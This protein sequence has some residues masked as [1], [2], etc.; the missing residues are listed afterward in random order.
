MLE[1][2]DKVQLHVI[3]FFEKCSNTSR[4]SNAHLQY[5]Y[6]T[7]AKFGEGQLRGVDYTKKVPSIQNMLEKD[8]VQHVI[9]FFKYCPI[10]SKKSNA[11]PQY[12][13]K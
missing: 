13:H 8:K 7:F 6:N 5:V 11:H 10:A 9:F 4:K 12:V 1:K 3:F 2:N